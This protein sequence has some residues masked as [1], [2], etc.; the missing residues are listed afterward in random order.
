LKSW[1]QLFGLLLALAWM[2]MVHSCE[3]AHA[4]GIELPQQGEQSQSKQLPADN[5]DHCTFCETMHAGGMAPSV[6]KVS[7]PGFVALIPLWQPVLTTLV[8]EQSPKVTAVT[9]SDQDSPPQ[10]WQF[11]E[12]T[13]LPPRAPSLL[14]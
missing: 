13:A 6:V 9:R 2:P 7:V 11:A 12:R 8:V 4:L 10:R 5:C 14:A 1:R 3:I